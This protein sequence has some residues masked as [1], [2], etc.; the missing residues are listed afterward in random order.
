MAV[1]AASE[2]LS[3]SDFGRLRELIH[4]RC[5]ISLN[6]S[7][8][9]ML[10]ARVRR[11]VS[12]LKMGSYRRYCEYLFGEDGLKDE[13]IH[14][15]DVVTTN[16]TDFF[17]EPEH[18]KQLVQQVL[19]SL[20]AR[21]PS[22][23]PFLAW[24][25]G[26]STGEEPYTIAMVLQE[27]ANG[28]PGFEFNVL[29]TDISTAVLAKAERAI[30]EEDVM[31]PVPPT[32]RQRYFMRGRDAQSELVRVVPELRKTVQFRRLNFMDR[33]FQMARPADVIF[34]R[35]VIIYFERAVQEQVLQKL[36]RYLV[37]GGYAFMGHAE[38]LHDMDLPW[39][40]AGPALY[41]KHDAAG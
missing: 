29:A 38:T 11:R 37:P 27:Y 5:G 10:E 31:G 39:S 32:L 22:G 4:A 35:N 41:R 18:F 16:K 13:L 20:G 33:D 14:L 6:E 12:G 3:Q 15:I 34:C 40:P 2:K 24:S 23:R 19:P 28:H 25:A 9:T 8:R 36:S 7:K 26:C 1:Q 30:F 21:P 17:R